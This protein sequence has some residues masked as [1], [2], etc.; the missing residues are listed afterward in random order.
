MADPGPEPPAAVVPAITNPAGS[1][2]MVWVVAEYSCVAPLG[3]FIS[4]GIPFTT[5]GGR[6]I[7]PSSGFFI[8]KIHM[9]MISGY[10]Q[11]WFKRTGLC[12][13][14]AT[15]RPDPIENKG[16]DDGPEAAAPER[17]DGLDLL[18]VDLLGDKG[19]TT[20]GAAAGT[21]PSTD[22]RVLPVLRDAC[23]RRYRGFRE[24]VGAL[25]ESNWA[26]W[27]VVGPLTVLWRLQ[28]IMQHFTHPDQRHSRWIS[29]CKLSY[30]DMGATEHQSIMRFVS[31]A[32]T[33]DQLD[34]PQ[35]ASMELLLRR[36]QMIE[37]RYKEKVVPRA[38]DAQ[39]PFQDVCLYTRLSQTRGMLMV[40]P[41]LEKYIG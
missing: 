38:Q 17:V 24:G 31:F 20:A 9:G 41:A 2:G 8:E 11:E 6:A 29:D 13:P 5:I 16:D 7:D 15:P 26:D 10:P 30:N 19:G 33:Y 12:D 1:D 27:P 28:F 37:L 34:M 25:S 18:K 22:A 32:M 14:G 35:L 40:R 39:D 23:R 21:D 36:A 4:P 3:T